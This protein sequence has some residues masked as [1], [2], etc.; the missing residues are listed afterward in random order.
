[1][2]TVAKRPP[3]TLLQYVPWSLQN[4]NRAGLPKPLSLQ[5]LSLKYPS[6]RAGSGSVG[7]V[8][9]GVVSVIPMVNIHS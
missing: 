2:S 6:A 4:S 7:A 1:M 3:D 8:N 9:A 5:H